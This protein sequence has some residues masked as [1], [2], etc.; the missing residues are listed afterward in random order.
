MTKHLVVAAA[1]LMIVL[2]TVPGLAAQAA[3]GE[4]DPEAKPPVTE[5]DVK[6]VKRARAFSIGLESCRYAGLR[7]GCENL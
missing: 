7:G 1:V 2:V 6:I 4:D 5:A 3:K